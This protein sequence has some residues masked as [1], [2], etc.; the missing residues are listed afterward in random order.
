[1][2]LF[3]TT[4]PFCYTMLHHVILNDYTI[5]ATPNTY[6]ARE[7]SILAMKLSLQWW[8]GGE[9]WTAAYVSV[10]ETLLYPSYGNIWIVFTLSPPF[11]Q[12]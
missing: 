7:T 12:H 11:T 10:K 2:L 3:L 4:T 9:W 6:N 8:A 5:V 1:M